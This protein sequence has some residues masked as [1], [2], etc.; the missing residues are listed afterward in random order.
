MTQ[1]E[2][3][4]D[5]IP[6]FVLDL[7]DEKEIQQVELHLA[8]CPACQ[9][10]VRAYQDVLTRLAVAAPQYA[11]APE[12]KARVLAG[13]TA[14]AR[15][16]K[17][18]LIPKS[19]PPR[20]PWWQVFGR[21]FLSP[22]R[23]WGV[24]SLILIIILGISN[25]ILWQQVNDLKT[26]P[27]QQANFQVV[28]LF[29][30]DSAPNSTGILVIDGAGEYGTLVVDHLPLLSAEYQYQLW[31]IRDGVRTSGGVFSVGDTGYGVLP[32]E[33]PEPLFT[34]PSFGVTIEPAGGSLDPTGEKVLGG[35]L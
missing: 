6:E 23:V 31:L 10:E 32:I 19:V 18:L 4:L 25:L 8:S 2:H 9:A 5:W 7:L 29:G 24:V 14:T 22:Q 27:T 1:S 34:Y 16:E 3:V 11:P 17:E 20:Q 15:G 13:I 21:I 33:S 12:L 35:D 28:N 26:N 30:T